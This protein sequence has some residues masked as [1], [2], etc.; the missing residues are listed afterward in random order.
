MLLSHSGL[1]GKKRFD[2]TGAACYP[3]ATTAAT[4]I[5]NRMVAGI[6]VRVGNLIGVRAMNTFHRYGMSDKVV[7][8]VRVYR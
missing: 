1:V 5:A 7:L 6:V 4:A 3:A 2:E 8:F